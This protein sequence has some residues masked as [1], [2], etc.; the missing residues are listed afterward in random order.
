MILFDVNIVLAMHRDDHPHHSVV[1]AWFNEAVEAAQSFVV[2]DVVWA[3]F[4]RLATDRRIYEVPTTVD[5]T[6]AFMRAVR[7]HPNHV[8]LL[9]GDEHLAIFEDVCRRFDATGELV[10]D[11]YLAA[12]AIEQGCEL[13]S[14]DR[15]FARFE[16]LRWVH[17]GEG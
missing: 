14:F 10:P 17:P 4:V 12:L 11:A 9:P 2:P 15:D 8:A 1:R 13:A 3:S 16:G 5:A 7:T 6:F